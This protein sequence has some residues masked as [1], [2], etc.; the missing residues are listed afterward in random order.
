M[1]SDP[2]IEFGATVRAFA[3]GLQVFGRFRLVR[4][5][6]RGG[7][8]VVWLVRDEHLAIEVA[9]KFLPE[10][11]GA[12]ESAVADLARETRQARGLAHPHIVRVFDFHHDAT[13]AGI[14]MEFIDGSTLASAR[15]KRDPAVFEPEEL[16]PWVEQLSGALDYAHRKA[17][18]VHRDLKPANLMVGSD[19]EIK[20]A[21]FGISASVS[22][23]VTQVSRVASSSGSPPYMSPQQIMGERPSPSDDIYALGATLYELITSKPPFFTGNIVVQ[24]QSKVPPPMAERRAEFGIDRPPLPAVWEE[25]IAACLAKQAEERPASVREM[26]ERLC[27]RASAVPPESISEGVTVV[28]PVGAARPVPKPTASAGTLGASPV[29]TREGS[30]ASALPS[31]GGGKREASAAG[32]RRVLGGVLGVLALGALAAVWWLGTRDDAPPGEGATVDQTPPPRQT[33]GEIETGAVE[34]APDSTPG[35]AAPVS[36]V[37][38]PTQPIVEPASQAQTTPPL[39]M[40]ALEL[41]LV[42]PAWEPELMA[43]KIDG[44]TRE[45]EAGAGNSLRFSEVPVGRREISVEHPAYELWTGLAEVGGGQVTVVE[46]NPEP[47]PALLVL[48]VEGASNFRLL[49]D[50]QPVPIQDGA[51]KIPAGRKFEATVVAPGFVSESLAFVLPPGGRETWEVRLRPQELPQ[52]GRQWSVPEIELAMVWIGPGAFTMGSPALEAGRSSDEGPQTQVRLTEGFWLGKH[53]V[54]QE[55]WTAIMGTNP[56]KFVAAGLRAPVEQVSWNDAMEFC[57]KLTDRE[58]AAGRLP[59]G[60]AYDLPTEAQWEYACRAGRGEAYGFGASSAQLYRYGNFADVN[61]SFGWRDARQDDGVGETTAAVGRYLPNPWGLHD[62]HGNVW[63][64]CADRYS[65]HLPGGVVSD[66]T[67]PAGGGGRVTRGGSWSFAA[68]FCRS[69]NRLSKAPG[70]RSH[71]L[72][73][74]LALVREH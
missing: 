36:V 2:G 1:E 30:T 51:A 53:E 17:R 10:A 60:L 28:N 39:A 7:M 73:F 27:R 66:P 74:R 5:L 71:D 35:G 48:T 54:T 16:V 67:G 65:A 33:P 41:S 29:G 31:G 40:G 52:E 25:T 50:G 19:G 20:V 23:S 15:L 45:P 55:E 57:Q 59:A 44:V 22:E 68:S 64:W 49:V 14:S 8:G 43:V 9:L 12:D 42:E 11:V 56:S 47:K 32:K 62:M 72:G 24:A 26:A 38:A 58:R 61:V 63:E 46:V 21:D 69:A 70:S 18:V 34:A 3:P 6:G 37:D 4:M 13:L